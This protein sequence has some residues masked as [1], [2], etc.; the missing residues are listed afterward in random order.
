MKTPKELLL[1]RHRE[2]QPKLDAV[3]RE[4]VAGLRNSEPMAGKPLWSEMLLS[5]RWHLGALSAAWMLIFFLNM[6]RP[7]GP[8][9]SMASANAPSAVQVLASLHEQRRQ[10]QQWTADPSSL[11]TPEGPVTLPPRRSELQF[12]NSNNLA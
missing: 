12:T 2:I 8:P 4:V 7:P 5:F 6:E 10:L 9:A 1:E 11:F 3:R